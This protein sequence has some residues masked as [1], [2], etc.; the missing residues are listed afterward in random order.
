[1][2][3]FSYFECGH[4]KTEEMQFFNV[5][6]QII[7]SNVVCQYSQSTIWALNEMSSQNKSGYICPAIGCEPNKIETNLMIFIRFCSKQKNSSPISSLSSNLPTMT[8]L[9]SNR[10]VKRTSVDSGINLDMPIPSF[11]STLWSRSRSFLNHSPLNAT[12]T[13]F[14]DSFLLCK[15]EN[16][17]LLSSNCRYEWWIFHFSNIQ[18]NLFTLVFLSCNLYE[19]FLLKQ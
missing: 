16:K 11:R 3:S 8:S 17:H 6:F 18:L 5:D 19:L 7:M 10:L 14:D 15:Y 12:A 9:L 4:Y 13:G 1:M 2:H